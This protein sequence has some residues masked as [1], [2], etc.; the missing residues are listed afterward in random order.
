ML[1]TP[2]NQARI[3]N[4]CN[5]LHQLLTDPLTTPNYT[6]PILDIPGPDHQTYADVIS[7]ILADAEVICLP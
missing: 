1:Q 2:L 5:H 7:D 6:E 4:F 3:D